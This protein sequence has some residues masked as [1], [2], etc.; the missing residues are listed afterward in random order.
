ML[1]HFD[2]TF[3]LLTDPDFGEQKAQ[4]CAIACFHQQPKRFHQQP[5]Q[6]KVYAGKYQRAA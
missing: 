2:Y 1:K 3:R 6:K 5:K 4:S